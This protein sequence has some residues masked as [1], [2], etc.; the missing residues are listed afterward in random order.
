ML[1]I[2]QRLE[3][4]STTLLLE[5]K[6]LAPWVGEVRL[7]AASALA[8][9][10]LKLDLSDLAFADAEGVALLQSLQ[11]GGVEYIHVSEFIGGLLTL[12]RLAKQS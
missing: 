4:D 9:G 2:H 3:P 10:H 12:V 8:R 11:Q 6:L 7:A 1:R 5:G